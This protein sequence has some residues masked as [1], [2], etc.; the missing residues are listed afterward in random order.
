MERSIEGHRLKWHGILLF[1]VGLL[2]GVLIPVFA[3][4]RIGLSAHVATL[5]GAMFLVI[6]GILWGGLR[7][8]DAASR[9]AFWLAV[10]GS[11]LSWLA[12]VAAAVFGTS[13][14]TPIAGA[15]HSA[16]AWQEFMVGAGLGVGSVAIFASS[17]MVLYGLRAQEAQSQ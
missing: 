10:L 13:R 14:A 11:Y 2:T 7:L 6:L 12:L 16:A 5:M 15:G 1:I 17:A 9:A 3:N 4:P 8:S